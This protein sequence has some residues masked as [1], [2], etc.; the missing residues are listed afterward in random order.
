MK[1]CL[2]LGILWLIIYVVGPF[3][4]DSIRPFR[5]YARTVDETGIMPGALYYTDVPQSRDAEINNRNA[6]RFMVKK[7]KNDPQG[8][9]A[10]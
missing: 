5:E 7:G 2:A 6:I 8:A 3:L 4:V 1:L 9:A 10:K